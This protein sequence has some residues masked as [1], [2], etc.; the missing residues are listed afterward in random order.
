MPNGANDN[1]TASFEPGL[2]FFEGLAIQI[3]PPQTT[4]VATGHPGQ[5]DFSK[6]G[7]SAFEPSTG[8]FV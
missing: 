2:W 7:N 3:I 5:L 8:P 1:S 6:P 4:P